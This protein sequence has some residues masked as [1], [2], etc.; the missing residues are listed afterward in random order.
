MRFRY[1]ITPR[2]TSL[3]LESWAEDLRFRCRREEIGWT[4]TALWFPG[5]VLG[6]VSQMRRYEVL[7][8]QLY[9]TDKIAKSLKIS[10]LVEY[11]PSEPFSSTLT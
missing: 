11:L 7:S 8:L 6:G 5:S 2:N 9:S 3:H 4:Y 10:G 1:N